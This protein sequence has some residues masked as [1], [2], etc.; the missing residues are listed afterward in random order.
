MRIAAIIAT[1]LLLSAPAFAQQVIVQG[2]NHAAADQAV[3][4]ADQAH[5]D[6]RFEADQARRDH[7]IANYDAATGHYGAARAADGA[8]R[9]AAHDTRVDD[10]IVRHD[11]QAAHRDDSYKLEAV[12]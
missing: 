7:A 4:A 2:P 12:P 11:V 5:R 3:G 9:Q 8:A 10:N 1:G 6:A